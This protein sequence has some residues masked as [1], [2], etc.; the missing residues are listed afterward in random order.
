MTLTPLAPTPPRPDNPTDTGDG[1]FITFEGIDGAG[2]SSHVEWLAE[3]W[4]ARGRSVVVTREPGGTEL[5]ERLRAMLLDEPMDPQ[6]ELLLVFAARREHLTRLISPAL[7]RGAVVICDRFTDSTYAYQGAGRGL[8]LDWIETLEAQV[9]GGLQPRRTYLFDLPA[10]LAAERRAAA[11]SADRFEAEEVSF[12]ERV[13]A[14]YAGR[15]ARAA[16]RFLLIDGRHPIAAIRERLA[17][18][19]DTLASTSAA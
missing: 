15:A 11:R 9:Q 18:D 6:T 19:I 13:R 3:Q 1:L 17:S 5:A 8:R 7:T 12:F 16:G 14:G 2:K 10:A 4:R